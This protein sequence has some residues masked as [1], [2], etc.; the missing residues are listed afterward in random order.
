MEQPRRRFYLHHSRPPHRYRAG[1]IAEAKL[2]SEERRKSFQRW[3]RKLQSRKR[4]LLLHLLKLEPPPPLLPTQLPQSTVLDSHHHLLPSPLLLFYKY[5]KS[6]NN[7]SSCS[8]EQAFGNEIDVL[9]KIFLSQLSFFRFNDV[10]GPSLSR[11]YGKVEFTGFVAVLTTSLICGVFASVLTENIF[12][13]MLEFPHFAKVSVRIFLS[14][15]IS[16]VFC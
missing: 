3:R 10:I 7:P 14:S 8:L 11:K 2:S 6:C 4:L 15:R 12:V 16:L 1:P 13:H 9:N 5:E